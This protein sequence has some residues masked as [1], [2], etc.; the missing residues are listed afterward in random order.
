MKATFEPKRLLPIDGVNA[1]IDRGRLFVEQCEQDYA[2]RIEGCCDAIEAG[3]RRIVMLSGPSASGKTTT[4]H[5][6]AIEIRSRGYDGFVVSLDDFFLDIEDYPRN[7][8]GVPD[9]EHIRALDVECVNRCLRELVLDGATDMPVYDFRR[10]RRSDEIRHVEAQ[11]GDFV[12]I[13]GIHALNPLLSSS[14]DPVSIFKIYASLRTEYAK[15]SARVVATRDL[16]ITRR[17]VR[18]FLARGH[19][20]RT[21]LELWD[22]L[23]EGEEKWIKPFRADADWILDTSFVYE[24]ALLLP[25]LEELC[26][27]PECGGDHRHVLIKLLD[28][29]RLFHPLEQSL[30]P[31]NSMLR[32]FTGGLELAAPGI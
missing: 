15:D 32:E 4:T 5:K 6:L 29:Y 28:Q 7:E 11:E 25:W 8:Q 3:G 20:V 1:D 22:R 30:V 9:F 26:L 21:T 18:D 2:R 27:D 10:Q 17:L 24:P 14:I 13:E 16:R 31:T 23:R 19:S 12:F